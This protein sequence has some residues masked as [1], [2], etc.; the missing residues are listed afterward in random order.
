VLLKYLSVTQNV[1]A[2]ARP[3][4]DIAYS[5]TLDEEPV[6]PSVTNALDAPVHLEDLRK[7]KSLQPLQLN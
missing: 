3:K 1:G 7:I 4:P 6:Q 5:L 2:L